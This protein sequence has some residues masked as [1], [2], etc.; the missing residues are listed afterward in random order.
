MLDV[1]QSWTLRLQ[2]VVVPIA[3]QHTSGRTSWSKSVSVK[4]VAG[5]QI[6][7]WEEGR[8]GPQ[9]GRERARGYARVNADVERDTARGVPWSAS[10]RMRVAN[11]E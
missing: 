4:C 8:A 9:E 3:A 2:H 6:A 11:G 7:M 10:R 1:T 5:Q